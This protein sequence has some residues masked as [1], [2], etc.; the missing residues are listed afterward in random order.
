MITEG[1]GRKELTL[2][3]LSD[4]GAVCSLLIFPLQPLQ[5]TCMVSQPW[6]WVL[7]V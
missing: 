1:S 6:C 3:E 5:G 7:V 4:H 2:V